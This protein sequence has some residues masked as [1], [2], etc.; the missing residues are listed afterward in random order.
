M[1]GSSAR[2]GALALLAF[3]TAG[4]QTR[5]LCDG[6]LPPNDLKIPIG[7]M[8]DKGITKAQFDKVM[9]QVERIYTPI[10]QAQGGE[11]VVERAWDDA[12]VNA[13]ATQRGN[14][15]IIHMYG[16][17]ARHE[18]ITQDG[19]ALVACHELGH[20]IGGFPKK[21]WASNEGQ[22]DYYANLKCLRIVFTDSGSQEFTRMSGSDPIAER[23]CAESFKAPAEQAACVRGSMAGMSVSSLFRALRREDKEPRFDTPDPKVVSRT[24]DAH[25]GTQCRLDTYYQGSI[26]MRPVSDAL[27]DSDPNKGTCTR[28]QGFAAGIRPFCWYK[29]QPSE[30]APQSATPIGAAPVVPSAALSTLQG[31]DIWRGL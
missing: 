27:S 17:L 4:P 31:P 12:T 24:D 29:P 14:K 22:A 7:A 19:M 20:H 13:Y 30:G 6:F 15:F 9:D 18:A 3:L 23:S 8:E 2:I 21:S 1:I 25:P 5:L 26:C 11:L 28:S 10:I 16:G